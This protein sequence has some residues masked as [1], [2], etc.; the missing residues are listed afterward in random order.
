MVAGKMSLKEFI[1]RVKAQV[2]LTKL[3]EN[4]QKKLLRLANPKISEKEAEKIVLTE[5][6]KQDLED[7]INREIRPKVDKPDRHLDEIEAN[8][9]H[10]YIKRVTLV[11]EKDTDSP[12]ALKDM[13]LFPKVPTG[14]ETLEQQ[15]QEFLEKLDKKI[16]EIDSIRKTLIQYQNNIL[17]NKKLKDLLIAAI[18]TD[19]E[20]ILRNYKSLKKQKKEDFSVE[21]FINTLITCFNKMSSKNSLEYFETKTLDEI[22]NAPK[23]PE[24][25]YEELAKNFP[26]NDFWRF[27][28]DRKKQRE[29]GGYS[30]FE[31]REQG[32]ML[33]MANGWGATF[34]SLNRPVTA[35]LIKEIHTQTAES[36][37]DAP[38]HVSSPRKK[39]VKG[40]FRDVNEGGVEFGF[41]TDNVGLIESSILLSEIGKGDFRAIFCLGI[42]SFKC[43]DLNTD[44]ITLNELVVD[45]CKNYEIEMLNQTNDADK[46]RLIIQFIKKLEL[47]HPFNDANCRTFC[48]LLLNRELVRNGFCPSMLEDPNLFDGYSIDYLVNEVIQGMHAAKHIYENKNSAEDLPEEEQSKRLLYYKNSV[49]SVLRKPETSVRPRL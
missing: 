4:D 34:N 26:K 44:E 9:L 25:G 5:E 21:D 31:K 6:D 27:F 46:L 24:G 33:A 32:Y 18:S 14:L 30:G 23:L 10:A 11:K 20:S 39:L 41:E 16:P 3:E 7:Y 38:F 19:K 2:F 40:E 49:D 35:D 48:I 28:C 29:E 13:R 17:D 45:L 15:F 1:E 36:G 22:K 37:G 43:V 12:C 47:L 42:K 8:F